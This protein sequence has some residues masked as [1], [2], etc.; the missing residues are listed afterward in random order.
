V[1]YQSIIKPFG[2]VDALLATTRQAAG[3]VIADPARADQRVTEVAAGLD[4]MRVAQGAFP[5][6]MHTPRN[7]TAA[8]LQSHVANKATHENK[9]SSF[10]LGVAEFF[11]VQFSS[12]DWIAWAASFFT[13]IEDIV[14]ADRPPASDIPELI[15]NNCNV[16]ILGDWGT[17]LYGAP[18]CARSVASDQDGYNLL[19]HMGD[20]YYSGTED[21]VQERFFA[22]WPNVAGATSRALN[23]NHEMYTGG[24]AYF[25]SLL[26]KFGQ[27]TSYFA[28]QNDYWTL[29]A[30]DTAYYQTIGGQ[31]GVIDD[32]QVA[33][34]GRVLQACGDRKVALFSHH[35]PMTLLDTNS[36]GNLF[37]ALGEFLQTGK[38]V[39][40]YWGHE[41]RCVLYDLHPQYK[42]TG[43]CI[44]HSGFPEASVD[45]SNAPASP[46]FG[47]Q[48][49]YVVGTDTTPGGYVLDTPNLYI[50]GF[51][52]HF[53]PHGFMRLEFRNEHLTEYVRPPDNANI[54][55]K[56][57]A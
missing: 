49:R 14:L 43:R 39:A 11:D 40:W 20:V 32:D 24:H 30:L 52:V 1:S 45:L 9:L 53:A 36:G 7:V 5:Q 50:P 42:F 13:W 10:L 18:V 23:G 34:L 6:V 56:D 41:H 33:W 38:V 21:E 15:G 37:A 31:E 16:A 3:K 29:V 28:L 26:P 17:G 22:L 54:Y 2:S 12:A 19:L 8:L 46:D 48:W 4:A 51:E 25:G 47:D 35:Q 57:L 55:L 44:G 27:A